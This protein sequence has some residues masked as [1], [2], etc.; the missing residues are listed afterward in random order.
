MQLLV[1]QLHLHPEKSG[2]LG[3]VQL[4]GG[5]H[6][7]DSISAISAEMRAASR[8]KMTRYFMSN[9]YKWDELM[10]AFKLPTI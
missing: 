4:T 1:A 10:Q 2:I 6:L 9:N 8:Q 3:A 5:V 7:L